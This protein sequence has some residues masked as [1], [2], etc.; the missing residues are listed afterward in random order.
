VL[1][2]GFLCLQALASQ[3]YIIVNHDK[4]KKELEVRE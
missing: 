2:G 3:G 1:G 4:L